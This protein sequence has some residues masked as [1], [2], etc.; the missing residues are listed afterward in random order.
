VRLLLPLLFACAD[1][2][3]VDA[4]ADAAAYAA[5][6]AAIEDTPES[7][8][9]HCAAV[10]TPA[11]RG[12]CIT[13]GAEALARKATN[14]AAALCA[15]LP[16]GIPRDEC[17]FQVA[18]RSGQA[19]RCAD[20]GRFAED[21]RMHVWSRALAEALPPGTPLAEAEPRVAALAADAGFTAADP[22]PWVVLARYLLGRDAPL[23][24]ARCDALSDAKRRQ[25][26]KDAARDLFHDR[27]N[28]ARDTGTFPC[29][30]GP[31][32]ALLAHTPDPELDA[33]VAERRAGDLCP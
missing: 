28:H 31:L 32:P 9:A 19:G 5:A 6:L 26:C 12:D 33:I 25:V 24:R 23:D 27:L 2:P 29:A 4:A 3:P 21:C 14:E 11:L 1:D 10:R 17:G 20:A 8:R 7:T 16:D 13:A 30:G 18:E 15:T 22:R